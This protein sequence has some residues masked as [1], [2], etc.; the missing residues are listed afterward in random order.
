MEKKY[1]VLKDEAFNWL[2]IWMAA[3]SLE[4]KG[5]KSILKKFKFSC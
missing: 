3:S 2:Q 5:N 4:I 1:I